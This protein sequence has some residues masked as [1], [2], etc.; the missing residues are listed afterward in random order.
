MD[1]LSQ[2][3]DQHTSLFELPHIDQVHLN[4]R[5]PSDDRFILVESTLI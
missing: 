2:I 4:Y 1:Y 3:P 5:I